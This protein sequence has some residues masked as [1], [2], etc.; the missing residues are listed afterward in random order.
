MVCER[1]QI[2]RKERGEIGSPS[3]FH[4]LGKRQDGGRGKEKGVRWGE[5]QGTR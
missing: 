3:V 1:I 2:G 5:R 4:Q